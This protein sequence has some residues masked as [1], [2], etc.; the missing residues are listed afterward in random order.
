M[1]NVRR[2]VKF[3]DF[4]SLYHQTVKL[5]SPDYKGSDPDAAVK[6]F[7]KRIKNYELIYEPLDKDYDM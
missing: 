5:T 2:Q 7:E 4:Y 1:Y 6:D 3:S